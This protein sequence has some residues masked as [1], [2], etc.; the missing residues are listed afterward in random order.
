MI[1]LLFTYQEFIL[2][3]IYLFFTKLHLTSSHDHFLD[4]YELPCLGLCQ[5]KSFEIP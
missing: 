1:C 2:W 5:T 3:F 4:Q